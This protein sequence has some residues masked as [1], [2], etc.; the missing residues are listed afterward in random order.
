MKGK[1][2]LFSCLLFFLFFCS[3]QQS[4]EQ[5]VSAKTYSLAAFNKLVQQTQQQSELERALFSVYVIDAN[6]KVLSDYQSQQS[7]A[8]ASVLKTI[9]TASA[10][11]LLGADFKFETKLAYRGK[12]DATGTLQGDVYIIGGG[13]PTLGNEDMSLLFSQWAQKIKA[14]GIKKIAGKVIGDASAY[15]PYLIPRTWIWEDIGNYYGSGA[16]G[17]SINENLYELYFKPGKPGYEAKVLRM[18]PKVPGIEFI[19]EMKTGAVGTGDNGY[20]FGAPFTYKRYLRGSIPAG[21][22]EFKI[23]GALPDPAKLCAYWLA[24]ALQKSGVSSEG[25][26]GVYEA[27]VIPKTSPTVLHTEYSKNLA[28]I[29]NKTNTKSVNIFAEAILKQVGLKMADEGSTEAGAEAVE[30]YWAKKGIDMRGFFMEDGS[31]LSRYDGITTAQTAKILQAITK[32]SYFQNFYK[33]L[34]IAGETG[35]LR[36]MCKNT[37]AKGRVHAKSGSIKRVRCYAGYV[38]SLSKGRLTFAIFINNYSGKYRDLTPYY[39]ELMTA[40][41]SLTY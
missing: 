35:T 21:K 18:K 31:G 25:H 12:I 40:M 13:D 10:L 26:E 9:T 20:I 29:V 22:A 36:R 15:E 16:C 23:K 11:E 8:P 14:K 39:E 27:E 6:G 2:T 5:T 37:V 4:E 19:N 24:E 3:P 32:Q 30:T 38:E 34:A 17:L 33:S 28:E 7:M 41:T 1:L